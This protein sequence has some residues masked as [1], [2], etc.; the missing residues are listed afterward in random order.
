MKLLNNLL[1][2][3]EK[4]KQLIILVLVVIILFNL[5]RNNNKEGFF[6][7]NTLG[8]IFGGDKYPQIS[9]SFG[10]TVSGWVNNKWGM[11]D[12]IPMPGNDLPSSVQGAFK[13]M[14][15]KGTF[16]GCGIN[17]LTNKGM[18]ETNQVLE[19][20]KNYVDEKFNIKK[21]G[22]F[23]EIS[24][25]PKS[26]ECNPF[27]GTGNCNPPIKFKIPVHYKPPH[28]NDNGHNG[29][30]ITS[31]P[32]PK[33][34]NLHGHSKPNLHTKPHYSLMDT[35]SQ[36]QV[37]KHNVDINKPVKYKDNKHKDNKHKDNKDKS[38]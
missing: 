9:S 19:M 37:F 25:L 15:E 20:S 17:T 21:L 5:F 14:G 11:G 31:R 2:L 12:S 6:S 26:F 4:N 13:C 29:P 22:N 36:P 34:P 18:D 1:S 32:T 23:Y 33:L 16:V 8:N 7:I 35:K 3:V 24:W 38:K 10:N 27:N 28:I 30:H